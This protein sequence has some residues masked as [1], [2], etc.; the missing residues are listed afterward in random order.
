MVDESDAAAATETDRDEGPP[1]VDGHTDAVLRCHGS[2]R[3]FL[4]RSEDGHLDLPRAREGGLDVVT[5]ATF[6]PNSAGGS[7]ESTP[8]DEPAP[9]LDPVVARRET[10]EQLALPRRWAHESEA[11]RIV[12]RVA[13]LDAC[14]DGDALGGVLHLEG[15]GAVEPDCSNLDLLYAAGVRSI[16]PVWSRPNAFGHGVPLIHDETPDTG[17]GL[18]EAGER[19]V[20][21]CNE[22]GIV[23]D[24]AHMTAAALSDTA[25]V[26]TDPLVVSHGGAHAVSPSA[27]NYTDDQIE[28]I[29]E[30]D[31]LLG[32]TLATTQLRPDG[33]DDPD[34]P[35]SLVADHVEHVADLVGVEHV[36]LGTDFDGATIPDGVGDAAGFGAVLDA[37]RERGFEGDDLDAIAGGNWRRVFAATW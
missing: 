11:F 34:T 7:L 9:E 17:P 31:G 28:R 5:L 14:L 35:V 19:L 6:V 16:G 30:S 2:A 18:T 36:A 13:D 1:V 26:S 27:R 4:E 32:I 29:A 10:Y 20:R 25:A 12:E 24:G 33:A 22:R 3:S 37:L 21:A 8:P 23:V 15:A